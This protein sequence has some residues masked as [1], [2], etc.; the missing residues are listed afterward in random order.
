MTPMRSISSLGWQR[1]GGP[2]SSPG[3]DEAGPIGPAVVDD[4]HRSR[5]SRAIALADGQ[6][7]GGLRDRSVPDLVEA[8]AAVDR[9][10]VARSERHDRLASAGPQI[11]AWNS[12]GPP[13]VR[14]RLATARHDGQRCGSFSR[15]LLAKKACSRLEKTNSSAQSRQVNVRSSNT[16]H[17]LLG[18]QR[19]ATPR[20]SRCPMLGTAQGALQEGTRSVGP[21]TGDPELLG[22]KIRVA[23]SP[24]PRL[25]PF[26]EPVRPTRRRGA[27]PA[28]TRH[29][30]LPVLAL[31]V[32]ACSS[33]G[34]SP[35][36][37]ASAA[38][39]SSAPSA[40]PSPSA[41]PVGAIDHQT[42]ATDVLLRYDVGG[43]L[44]MPGFSATQTPIFTL[45]GDG[46][47]VFRNQTAEPPPA[48]G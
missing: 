28:L 24:F 21:G 44:M 43:G 39:P 41:G 20:E 17:T 8:G 38:P 34:A 25:D 14:A 1:W 27:M 10:V 36:P 37:S 2:Q 4:C 26:R 22:V 33:S 31:A 16:L 15:P 3:I 19:S 48:I 32:V 9:S 30:L 47:V 11:A 18:Q 5:P 35:S 29:A 23:S 12:R 40:A 13:T 6:T 45:Y 42:G 7:L 46:T